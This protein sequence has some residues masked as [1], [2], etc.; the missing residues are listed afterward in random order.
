MEIHY[1]PKLKHIALQCFKVLRPYIA[2]VSTN[3]IALTF[4]IEIL[5]LHEILSY[6]LATVFASTAVFLVYRFMVFKIYTKENFFVQFKKF[7]SSFF[8]F[9]VV[10]FSLFT[11][12]VQYFNYDYLYVFLILQAIGTLI[13]FFYYR[14]AIFCHKN[15]DLPSVID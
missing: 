9:R 6:A 10:E 7:I 12:L 5:N 15:K 4:C 13:R 1:K 14:K 2:D 11:L 8:L 3:L